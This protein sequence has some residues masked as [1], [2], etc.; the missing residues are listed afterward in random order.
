M[1][2]ENLYSKRSAQNLNTCHPHLRTL[3]TE[4]LFFF[5]HSMLCGHR[6]KADQD[7]AYASGNSQLPWPKGKHNKKPSMAVDVKPYPLDLNG[8]KDEVREQLTFFAGFV[9]GMAADKGIPLRWGGDWNRDTRT[10]DNDWDDLFHF[11]LVED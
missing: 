1:G 6:N 3:F 2:Q 10:Q 4:V 9:M 5:D 8:P 7:R 11:E